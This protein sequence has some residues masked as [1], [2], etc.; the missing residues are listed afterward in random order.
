M[1][2]TEK[3]RCYVCKTIQKAH[4]KKVHD[5]VIEGE[6]RE[7]AAIAERDAPRSELERCRAKMDKEWKEI[8]TGLD[9]GSGDAPR[10]K[11]CCDDPFAC[12][13]GANE[14]SPESA[15]VSHL[16]RALRYWFDPKAHE[17]LAAMRSR[18]KALKKVAEAAKYWVYDFPG[19][20]V[21]DLEANLKRAV[22]A[23]DQVEKS[24]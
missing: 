13:C 10:C 23:L 16:D 5:A 1:S 9:R 18:L 17:E 21:E 7:A 12:D 3:D 19:P 11:E 14:P 22:R 6:R 2:T 20:D 4:D 15:G 8:K 24:K